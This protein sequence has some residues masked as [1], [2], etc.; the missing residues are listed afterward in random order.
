[1]KAMNAPQA[2]ARFDNKE[3]YT[4][5][6]ETVI[7]RYSMINKK[8]MAAIKQGFSTRE[9][10]RSFKAAR[11]YNYYIFDNVNNTVVR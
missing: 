6:T 1:M 3:N 4:M 10:A 9:A 2:L 11:G 8:T 7:K 5:A